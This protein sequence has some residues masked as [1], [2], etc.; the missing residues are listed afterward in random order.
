MPVM[1]PQSPACKAQAHLL[2][3]LS[4]FVNLELKRKMQLG[5]TSLSVN[6]ASNLS[7][8][9]WIKNIEWEKRSGQSLSDL[10]QSHFF[11]YLV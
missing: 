4:D 10:K 6:L 8:S 3:C 1:K 9:Y 7:R 5:L 2:N 11:K